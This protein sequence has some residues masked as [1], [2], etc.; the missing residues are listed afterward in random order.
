MVNDTQV[1]GL[2]R[3]MNSGK[4]LLV[5]AMNVGMSENTARKYLEAGDIP[6]RLKKGHWW[7]TRKDFFAAVWAWVEGQLAEFPGLEAKTLFGV[8]QR[9]HPGEFSDG[10]LRTL[11]RRVKVW[12]ATKGSGKEVFFP[13]AHLPGELGASDFTDMGSLG[14]TIQRQ[15][16][17]HLLYHFVLTYSNWEDVNVCFSESYE[18]LSLGLQNALWRLGGVPKKHRTDSLSAAVNNLSTV[19]EFT[20]RYEGLLSHYGMEGQKTQS[21]KAHENG[22]AEQSHYRIKRGIDQ[23]LML[24]G[25]RDFADREDYERFLHKTLAERNTGRQNRLAEEMAVLRALPESRLEDAKRF[26]A[27]VG[28]SSTIRVQHNVYSVHSRLIREKVEVRL[29]AE[30][31]DVWYGQ[32]RVE[33]LPRLRGE[34]KHR[35]DYRHVIDWLV[36][37]PGAFANYRY[38]S[39]LFPTSRFRVAYDMLKEQ[40]PAR[41]DKE[42]LQILHL[43][44]LESES[45]VN[46]ALGLLLADDQP[47]DPQRVAEQLK[48]IGQEETVR[49]PEIGGV[50]LREYDTLCTTTEV[51]S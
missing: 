43:A 19:E 42:Y 41:A 32:K 10:Q 45:G 5:A 51:G 49:D 9:E 27:T 3:L 16:F 21:G 40:S 17:D 7:R 22:D 39:D 20:R 8:L 35:I 26:H 30:H 2:I 37:K 44:A 29:F 11:Q 46:A 1:R 36:R 23:A 47:V 6:S 38:K 14:I 31:L 33:R 48:V 15:G 28:P 24:R 4:R 13:Q 18:S 50:D 12:R 34:E 25:S